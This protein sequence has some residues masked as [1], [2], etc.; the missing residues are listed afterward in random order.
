M[1]VHPDASTVEQD[2]AGGAVVD[3]S[4]QCS[5]GSRRQWH[6]HDLAAFPADLQDTMTVLLT[7]VFH[8]GAAGVEDPQ[9][10]QPEQDD[11]GE[12]VDVGTGAGGVQHGLELQVGQTQ[13][14][15]LRRHVRTAHVLGGR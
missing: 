5:L 9:A 3:K 2:R 13:G 12:V 15:G 4:L 8:V 1:P 7:Q 10:Q 11:E 6:E 14:G